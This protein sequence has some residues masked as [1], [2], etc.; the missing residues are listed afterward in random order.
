MTTP[1]DPQSRAFREATEADSWDGDLTT[2]PGAVVHEPL[3]NVG[4]IVLPDEYE[5]AG[6][7]SDRDGPKTL[8]EARHALAARIADPAAPDTED[9]AHAYDEDAD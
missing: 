4:H 1:T 2:L 9:E 8:A 3:T 7:D 5:A 6:W